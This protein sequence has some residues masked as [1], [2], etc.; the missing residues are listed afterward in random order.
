MVLLSGQGAARRKVPNEL[1]EVNFKKTKS[2]DSRG[3]GQRGRQLE[4]GDARN[5]AVGK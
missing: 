4:D 1:A 5:M 3:K 2:A